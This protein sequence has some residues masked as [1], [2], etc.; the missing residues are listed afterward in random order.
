MTANILTN[1][2]IQSYVL[3]V[4]LNSVNTVMIMIADGS[5]LNMI[6]LDVLV[7]TPLLMSVIHVLMPRIVVIQSNTITLPTLNKTTKKI[8]LN[9]GRE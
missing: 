4:V 7:S 3:P 5:A 6:P 8:W 9:L 1:V 2:P